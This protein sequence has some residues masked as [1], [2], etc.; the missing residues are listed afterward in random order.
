MPAAL[1]LLFFVLF[2]FSEIGI[3]QTQSSGTWS[4]CHILNIDAIEKFIFIDQ[5]SL[6]FFDFHIVLFSQL[7]PSITSIW[8]S[9]AIQAQLLIVQ[10]QLKNFDWNFKTYSF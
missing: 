8:I 1:V 7:I 10:Y 2:F 6:R 9:F 4:F 3:Y 5:T